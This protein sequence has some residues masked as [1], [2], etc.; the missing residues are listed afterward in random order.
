MNSSPNKT[1]S[2]QNS[3]KQPTRKYTSQGGS[4]LKQ[5]FKILLKLRSEN[6]GTFE[7]LY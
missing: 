2:E 7:I 5:E 6:S 1:V 4:E 3:I